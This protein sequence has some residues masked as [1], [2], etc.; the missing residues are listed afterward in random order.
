MP[1]VEFKN[2]LSGSIEE[3]QRHSSERLYAMGRGVW[4]PEEGDRRLVIPGLALPSRLHGTTSS[5]A[6][7][8]FIETFVALTDYLEPSQAPGGSV[9]ALTQQIV[10]SQNPRTLLTQLSF[11][12][13]LV[14]RPGQVKKLVHSYS[15]LLRSDLKEA[16][17]EAMRRDREEGPEAHLVSRQGTLAAARV[18]LEAGPWEREG[19][20]EPTLETSILLVH[21]AS[22]GLIEIRD[23]EKYL[24]KLPAELLMEMV[25][26]GLF[27]E[28]DDDYSVLDRALRVWEDLVTSPMHTP[29]RAAPR[30]L[31][32]EA[33]GSVDF[34]DFFALGIRLWTHAK[35]RDPI[36]EG[37][38]MTLRTS[39]PEV[40]MERRIVNEFLD[41]VA[42]T[43]EWFAS[44][45]DGRGSEYDFLPF[46]A[47]PVAHLGDELLVLDEA[48]LLQK[49]TMLG[50]FWAVHDNE[51]DHSS[52]ARHHWNQAHG[53]L[54]EALVTQ[55]L[56]EM[57][58]VT[59][60]RLGGKSFYSEQDI[61]AAFPK[62]R[63]GD[64]AV[65][66]GDYLLLF[67]VTGGQ[68][69]VGTRVEGDPETFQKDAEKLVFE[70]AERLH[71][72]CESLLTG[73]KRLTGY[74][75]PPNRRMVPVVVVGGG[76]PSDALSRRYVEDVLEQ[77]GWLQDEAI[78]VQ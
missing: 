55:R 49:F 17:E 30:E 15:N 13:H 64:A 74:D 70:E 25:R 32:E 8:D 28:N 31:L 34:E 11:L 46:Q 39:L 60:D 5:P 35:V 50:L 20:E 22:A 24:G 36:E 12:N 54:V 29:L 56:R 57:A 69:V 40:V 19:L 76:Y 27:N 3:G 48:Y 23:S 47:R 1:P 33:L 9:E 63:V 37:R 53:E 58:P 67:E 26:N 45:F 4:V 16:F 62:S 2:L 43:P 78:A 41:R 77:E 10:G 61:K 21:V 52:R 65:D 14:G 68:P 18:V 72:C 7:I 59:R 44:E 51:R 42:A 71:E 66:Y 38:P 73:Q 6:P 75:P